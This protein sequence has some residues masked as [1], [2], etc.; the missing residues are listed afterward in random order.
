MGVQIRNGFDTRE[1]TEVIKNI[2]LSLQHYIITEIVINCHL[3]SC[4]Q[5]SGDIWTL[6]RLSW[7]ASRLFVQQSVQID[8]KVNIK[9]IN[10]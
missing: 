10:Y 8:Q 9:F 3:V 2:Y 5:Y 6:K 1:W 7:L 4:I